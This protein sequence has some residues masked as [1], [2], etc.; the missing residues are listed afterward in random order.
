[1]ADQQPITCTLAAGDLRDRLAWIATLNRDALRGYDRADL[2]LRLRYAPKAVQQV[3][4]LMLR[5][6][7][8]CAFLT[9][10]MH[11]EPDAVTL[12]IKAPEE[13]PASPAEL[14]RCFADAGIPSGVMNLVYGVPSEISEYLIPHPI[15]RKMSFTGSTAVGK[16]L[17]AIVDYLKAHGALAIGFDFLFAESDQMGIAELIRTLEVCGRSFDSVR[18]D[19]AAWTTTGM[20]RTGNEDAFGLLQAVESRQDELTEYALILP[21]ECPRR[22]PAHGVMGDDPDRR[23]NRKKQNPKNRGA[24]AHVRTLPARRRGARCRRRW[25]WYRRSR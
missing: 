16:Q 5:E 10:E 12:T 18:L 7:A 17:A 20:V 9:F 8:C 22:A 11:E 1:M 19:I 2:T 6:K 21:R 3:W 23:D 14:I 25:H 13:T 4:E 24:G 15:I